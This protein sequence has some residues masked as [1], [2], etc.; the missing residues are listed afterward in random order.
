MEQILGYFTDPFY[1]LGQLFY[2]QGCI[3]EDFHGCLLLPQTT[4]DMFLK[5]DLR[6]AVYLEFPMGKLDHCHRLTLAWSTARVST[7]FSTFHLSDWV[8]CSTTRVVFQEKLFEGEGRPDCPCSSNVVL[9]LL[10]PLTEAHI[11]S[12]SDW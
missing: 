1:V 12:N 11:Q 8:W 3:L 5:S 10:E 4:F 2:F 6:I 7:S 9:D